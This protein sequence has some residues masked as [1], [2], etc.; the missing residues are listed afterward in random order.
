MAL[1]YSQNGGIA[2]RYDY[3]DRLVFVADLGPG[4]ETS[5]EIVDDTAILETPDGRRHT[6]EIPPGETRVFNRNGIVSIE[7]SQ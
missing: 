5:V 1:Q 3:D 7:V 2:R 4:T 6:L